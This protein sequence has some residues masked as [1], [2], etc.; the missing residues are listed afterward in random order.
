MA[1]RR[2]FTAAFKAQVVLELLSGGKSVAE[3]SRE[4]RVKPEI[5]ARWRRQ[6]VENAASVFEKSHTA[7]GEAEARIAE[8]ELEVAKKASSIFQ[9]LS[10]G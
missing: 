10:D 8:L 1:K 5:I 3:V 7:N 9:Q 2:Q 4:H 6:F